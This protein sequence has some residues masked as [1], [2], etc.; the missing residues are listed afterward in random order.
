MKL[1][2]MAK[3]KD[4]FNTKI[5][6]FNKSI[7]DGSQMTYVVQCD[8]FKIRINKKN[9][10]NYIL[11]GEVKNAT[12][13]NDG[14][15]M[16]LYTDGKDFYVRIRRGISRWPKQPCCVPS[17]VSPVSSAPFTGA[18]TTICASAR[19]TGGMLLVPRH[20]PFLRVTPGG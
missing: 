12:N 8:D 16:I 1:R 15:A 6:Q 18:G 10:N 11:L 14:E 20:H 2:K 7:H 17:S 3:S 9:K 4:N 19:N 5:R 13:S